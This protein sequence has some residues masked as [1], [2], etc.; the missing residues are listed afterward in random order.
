MSAA[1]ERLAQVRE[2]IAQAA[3][4]VGRDPGEVTLLGVSKRQPLERI[5]E[6]VAAGLE[7]LGENYA[8]EARSMRPAFEAL[9][10]QRR[11]PA[12]RWH[13]VGQLQRNKARPVVALFDLVETVDRVSL[14]VALDHAARAENRVLEILLQ[15]DLSDEAAE[16]PKGGVA[17]NA[18]PA[19]VTKIAGLEHLR[20]IGLM[21]IPA[22]QEDPQSSR[23]AFARLRELRDTLSSQPEGGSLRELSMGMSTDFEVAIEEGATI[24]R[25][26]TAIFGPRGS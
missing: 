8:Q 9:R 15:V 11:L 1:A 17:P 12:P 6:A 3:A 18:L 13:F 19:L 21:A 25:V 16:G 14:A 2:R 5:I 10:E 4:R 20:A 22:A 7:H 23:P 26:G 24:V